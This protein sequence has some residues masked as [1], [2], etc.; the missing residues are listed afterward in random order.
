[1]E[2]A[3]TELAQVNGLSNRKILSSHTGMLFAFAESAA[4]PFWMKDMLFPIDIVFFDSAWKI[5]LIEPNLQPSTFPKTF[6]GDVLSQ[7]VLEINAGEADIYGL[8]TGDQA[9]FLNK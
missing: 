3:S 9:I 6:G 2:V 1:M 4:H 7:Y 8:R 5:I